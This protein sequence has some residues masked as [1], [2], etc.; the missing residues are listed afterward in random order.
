MVKCPEAYPQISSLTLISAFRFA[1]QHPTTKL[2]TKSS[3]E[4][5]SEWQKQNKIKGGKNIADWFFKTLDL[6]ILLPYF[7]CLTIINYHISDKWNYLLIQSELVTI[8]TSGYQGKYFHYCLCLDGKFLL[9]KQSKTKRNKIK[10]WQSMND[11]QSRT[12]LLQG[13]MSSVLHEPG[14]ETYSRH[15]EH[16]LCAHTVLATGSGKADGPFCH[17]PSPTCPSNKLRN[18]FGEWNQ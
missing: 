18:I 7:S 11:E 8:V 6:N 12:N 4:C 3:R 10:I 16:L 13:E 2:T 14:R 5:M 15:I 1:H 9:W 17:S